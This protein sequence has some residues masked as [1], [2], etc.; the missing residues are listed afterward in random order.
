MR[1][2][3]SFSSTTTRGWWFYMGKRGR[4]SVV[5]CDGCSRN[6]RRDKAVFFE[7]VIFSNPLQRHEVYA[8]T[9]VPRLTREVAYCPGCGKHLRI[10]E[11]KQR[12]QERQ[13]E[14]RMEQDRRPYFNRGPRPQGPRPGQP[15]QGGRPPAPAQQPPAK[16]PAAQPPAPK[17]A[18]KPAEKKEE[19]STA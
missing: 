9:Y 1:R 6:V 12:L 18:E 15:A 14:R 17:P 3:T 7:K 13:R 4:E 19:Q 5:V 10:Y 8:E 2:P 11:K 16:Q